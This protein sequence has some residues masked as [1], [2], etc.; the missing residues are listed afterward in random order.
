LMEI[1]V[2]FP[3]CRLTVLC[4]HSH[5]AGETQ[6]LPNLRVATGGAEYGKPRLQRMLEIK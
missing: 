6:I 2:K 1:M 3:D 4:G 5:G